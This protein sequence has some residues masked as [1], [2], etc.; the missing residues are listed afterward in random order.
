MLPFD[1]GRKHIHFGSTSESNM[2]K[3]EEHSEGGKME[4]DSIVA[5]KLCLIKPEVISSTR[6]FLSVANVF[7]KTEGA[8]YSNL[9]PYK[10]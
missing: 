8:T 5:S 4:V 1:F 2:H 3:S 9:Y 7:D 10:S 6:I